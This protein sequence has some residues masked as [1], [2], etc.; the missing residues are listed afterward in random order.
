MSLQALRDFRM[1]G[2]RPSAPVMVI[3]GAKPF[4]LTDSHTFVLVTAN[5]RPEEMDFRPL[6]GLWVAVVMNR[7][8]HDLTQRLLTAMQHAS[9]KPYGIVTDKGDV[10]MGVAEPT[11]AHELNLRGIWELYR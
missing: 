8:L 9:A 11:Q 5:D 1:T 4:W 6:V 10:L 7:P 2:K 3:V